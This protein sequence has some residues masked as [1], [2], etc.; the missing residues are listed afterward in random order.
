[1]WPQPQPL[2]GAYDRGGVETMFDRSLN[3]AHPDR[4]LEQPRLEPHIAHRSLDKS[5]ACCVLT[6]VNSLILNICWEVWA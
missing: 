4:Q 3:T 1:M 5:V 2:M 6:P